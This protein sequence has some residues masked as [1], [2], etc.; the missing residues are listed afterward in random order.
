MS[1]F[2]QSVSAP[3]AGVDRPE[4]RKSTSFKTGG[5]KESKAWR[6]DN[7]NYFADANNGDSDYKRY[8]HELYK[9]AAGY[10]DTD[11]YKHMTDP[12]NTNKSKDK[13]LDRL[14]LNN[15]DIITPIIMA[16]MG[17]KIDRMV[18]PTVTAINSDIDSIKEKEKVKLIE[19][20]L[21]AVFIN[22]INRLRDSGFP[23]KDILSLE[24]INKIID[25]IK[26]EKSIT[27]SKS[28]EY[29]MVNNEVHRKFRKMFFNWIVTYTTFSIKNVLNKDI[30]YDPISPIYVN[31]VLSENK[32]FVEDGESA[33]VEFHMTL[34]EILD[35]FHNQLKNEQL[36]ILEGRT[37][38]NT[39][40]KTAYLDE[41]DFF[42]Q[43]MVNTG[44]IEGV[45]NMYAQ[46]SNTYT[47]KYVNW[48]SMVKIGE[49]EVTDS[50]GNVETIEVNE[51]YKPLE[52]EKVTWK[53]VNQVWEGYRID[54]EI[55][56]GIRPIPFQ[57][58]KFDNPSACKLLINGRSFMNAHYRHLSIVEKL[59]PYQQK[60]N[61]VNWHLNKLI[62]KNKDKIV[63]LPYGLIPDNEDLD[64]FDMMY[65][66][67]K[68]SY[69][70]LDDQQ[71]KNK[72]NALQHVRVLDVSL[73][74]NMSFLSELLKLIKS[75]AE[76]SVGFNRQRLGNIHA[77]DGKG[78]NEDAM[79]RSAIMTSEIYEQFEEFEEREWQGLLDL[80]KF[81][82]KDGKKEYF[83]NSDKKRALLNID[84]GHRELEYAVR[85]TRSTN[86]IKKLEKIRNQGQ[87]MIQN[88]VAVS[89]LIKMENA[90]S[91][92][93]MEDIIEEAEAKMAQQAQQA[94]ESEQQAEQEKV[95][96]E[97]EQEQAKL[98]YDYYKTDADNLT[99]EKVAIINSQSSL[100]GSSQPT[101]SPDGKSQM[102]DDLPSSRRME[103]FKKN[104]I[105]RQKLDLERQKIQVQRETN[106]TALENKVVGE[107]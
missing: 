46:D 73:S 99:K 62:N 70:F 92:S 59:K 101:V 35:N 94:Q 71:D 53:W 67:D 21:E 47:V 17:D 63:L 91:L 54:D 48:K 80:S 36:K 64:I 40:H 60:F 38:N 100:I 78:T 12:L 81:A 84:E 29:I 86:E 4:Q 23:D 34:S 19:Q 1:L 97:M 98:E 57:R 88:G 61:V 107:D 74:Q 39:A 104:E 15:Y 9:L 2:N 105:D 90:D 85:A 68:D 26:D 25:N 58:G 51:N 96:R 69:L 93:E 45:S 33:S 75:E 102:Q 87:A 72:I 13:R 95:A 89:T 7:V 50:F 103:E 42:Y 66:A 106:K 32:D 77:S 79:Q 3:R 18:K 20:Q 5:S 55:F 24:E 10:L 44:R 49:L 28:L 22:E 76:D 43:K 16:L 52:D 41:T 6:E 83:I 56:F 8:L 11:S 37:L 82:W 65:Y 31:Y 27:G 30:E 14:R